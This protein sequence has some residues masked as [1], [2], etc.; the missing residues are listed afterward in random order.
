[1]KLP[2]GNASAVVAEYFESVI[3]PAAAAAGGVAP[4]VAGMAGGLIA[5]RTPQMLKQYAPTLKALGVLDA[6]GRLDIDL[7][8]EEAVKALEK[9]PIVVGCYRADRSDLD[10]LKAIMGKYGA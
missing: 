3:L 8:Y 4:F 1:M 10:K 7:L 5:R 9:G 6:D 2:L